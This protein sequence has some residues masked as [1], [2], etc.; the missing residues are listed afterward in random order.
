MATAVFR[1]YDQKALDREY[2]NRAKVTNL[3]HYRGV[4]Y[5]LSERGEGTA[6]RAVSAA[7]VAGPRSII[8]R[9]KP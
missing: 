1:D 5:R 4:R 8:C 6:R 3:A 9:F 7:E 2:N